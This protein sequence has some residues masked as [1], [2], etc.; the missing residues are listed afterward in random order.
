MM[1]A[2]VEPT[3]V[4]REDEVVVEVGAVTDVVIDLSP[5]GKGQTARITGTISIDGRST[6]GLVLTISGQSRREINKE[7]NIIPVWT[8]TVSANGSFEAR[9]NAVPSRP[10]PSVTE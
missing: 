3:M 8:G 7:D 2:Q 5:S 4:H 6:A 10:G 1:I 9:T